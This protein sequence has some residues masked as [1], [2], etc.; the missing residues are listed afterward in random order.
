[1]VVILGVKRLHATQAS[2]IGGLVPAP[3]A[4]PPIQLP[5]NAL[6]KAIDHDPCACVPPTHAGDPDVVPSPW[7]EPD[8][9][10]AMVGTADG[11]SPSFPKFLCLSLPF[12]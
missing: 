1:M 2:H 3:A 9:V 10:L 4:L 12:R 8:L 5:A 11:R 6:G 7:T